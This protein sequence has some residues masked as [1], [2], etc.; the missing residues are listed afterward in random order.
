MEDINKKAVEIKT[1]A[2]VGL[3]DLRDIV[4]EIVAKQDESLV[5][6]K[7]EFNMTGSKESEFKL[8]ETMKRNETVKFLNAM[9]LGDGKLLRGY[10]EKALNIG[11]GADGGYLVPDEFETEILRNLNEYS[12]IRRNATVLPMSGD[13]KRLNVSTSIPITRKPA[14]L[15]VITGTTVTFAEPV[16]NA[17]K[18]ACIVDWSNE[19]LEDS[20]IQLV[21]YIAETIG[22]SMAN[23]EESDFVNGTVS[24]SEGILQVS[25]VTGITQN[26]GT[27][28]SLIQWDDLADMQ[29]ALF[30]VAN[31]E[32]QRGQFYMSYS[33]YNILRQLKSSTAGNY[34]VMPSAPTLE[35]P[36][37]A[38]G[39][40]IVVCANFPSTTATATKYVAFADGKRH[41]I[42]GDR[43]GLT[44]KVFDEG[45]IVDAGGSSRSLLTTDAQALRV[46]KRTAFVVRLPSGVV[47]L[48]TN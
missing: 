29:S 8:A 14:E 1:E 37:F 31:M 13:V 16:L 7:K 17:Q 5:A 35:T 39:R 44:M 24:G 3:S 28:F 4:K 38:W 22:E 25:G 18:Y 27:T 9:T 33:V 42:I 46:V 30:G 23:A 40:P 32:A 41:F 19:V 2:T 11:T 36:A 20:E 43:K 47:T 48:A 6:R 34:F 45:T 10:R 26:T 15:A 21:S 12:A